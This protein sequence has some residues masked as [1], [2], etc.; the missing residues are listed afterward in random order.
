MTRASYRLG[1][2][3]LLVLAA[4]AATPA[5]A[6][7]TAAGSTVT[8]TVSVNFQVGGV[9]QTAVSAS[10]SFTV[11]RKVN[12]TV[13][14][15]GSATTS[16]SPGQ[17]AAV[18]TFTVTNLSNATLDFA[19]T[20]AQQVG[21]AG[22]HSNTDNFDATNVKIYVDANANGVYDAGTDTLVTYL[23]ELAADTSKTVFVVADIPVS[24]VTNDVAAV[25]LT[26]TGREGGGA[27]SMGIALVDN[28]SS[29]NTAGM[30]TV[31][32]DGA[33]ATDAA[34]DAAF[35][36]KDDYT[37]LAAALTA[38]KTSKVISDPINNVTNPKMIPGAVVE[39][40]IAVANAA[41]SATATSVALS[42]VLPAATTYQASSL[43]LNGTVTGVTCNT[44][45]T[46]V[47]DAAD[48]DLGDYNSGT[49][50]VSGTIASLAAGVTRTLVFRVTIN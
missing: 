30:D 35:S 3:S 15:V 44:D 6:A 36:A 16:V 11:D 47:T 49:K 22:A 24:Q 20:A 38:T 37:V 29:A 10:N 14:E 26:A 7:G 4:L 41:G 39:Y 28:A 1:T 34:K 12:L 21:G 9:A 19:L 43:K 32:A 8:N 50:T 5:Y 13:A 31:F 42:D 23:D 45:G 46:A 33:G 17:L 2:A 48:A 25:T 40:C 27:G 18:T